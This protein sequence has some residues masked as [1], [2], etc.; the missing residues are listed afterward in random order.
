MPENFY[1]TIVRLLESNNAAGIRKGL[2]M[3]SKEDRGLNREN[4][5]H[6]LEILM[7]FFYIDALDRPDLISVVDEVISTIASMG[8]WVIPVLIKN[9]AAGDLKSQ[10]AVAHASAAAA[11]RWECSILFSAPIQN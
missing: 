1:N 6:I 5:N 2:S 3:L 8:E 7:S 9:L 10:M 4:L 11:I